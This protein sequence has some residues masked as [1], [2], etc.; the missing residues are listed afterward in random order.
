MTRM[1]FTQTGKGRIK[2]SKYTRNKWMKKISRTRKE[3]VGTWKKLSSEKHFV[4]VPFYMM[5][6]ILEVLSGD[7]N[8]RSNH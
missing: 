1:N 3:N 2:N 7:K 8:A 6:S 4:M 5:K